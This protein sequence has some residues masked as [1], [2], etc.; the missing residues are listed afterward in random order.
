VTSIAANDL[1]SGLRNFRG[2]TILGLD[3]LKSRYARTILGPFWVTI[4]HAMFVGAYGFWSSAILKQ[5]LGDQMLFF[6]AG[7]PIWILI[8]GSISEASTV[9]SRAANFIQAYD[10]PASLHVYRNVLGHLMSFGHN[11]VVFVVVAVTIKHSLTWS[12]LLAIPGMIIICAAAVGWTFLLG[13]IGARY[14]DVGPLASAILAGLFVLTP[15]FWRRGDVSQA[16]WLADFNPLYHLIEVVRAPLLGLPFNPTNWVV[17]I[18]VAL[19]LLI[20]GCGSFLSFRRQLPY[21]L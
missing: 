16:T 8:A 11:V 10:L 1:A 13:T 6:A 12:A 3:D 7:F 5:P 14:R 19:I 18:G 4:S 15:V 17:A 2:W 20:A 21:W 9:F